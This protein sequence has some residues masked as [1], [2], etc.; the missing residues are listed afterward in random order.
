MVARRV[1]ILVLFS[2]SFFSNTTLLAVIYGSQTAVNVYPLVTFPNTDTNNTMLGYGSFTNGFILADNTT[3]CLF[4]CLEPVS[5]YLDVNGGTLTLQQD[6]VLSGTSI[7]A[8]G[9]IIVGNNHTIWMG[10]KSQFEAAQSFT[11]QNVNVQLSSDFALGCTLTFMGNCA[12]TGNQTVFWLDEAWTGS[13]AG[14]LVVAPDAW[15]NINDLYVQNIFGTN[16]A[17]SDDT[18]V[19]TFNDVQLLQ[20][21]TFIFK[22]GVINFYGLVSMLGTN[23]FVYQS[24]MTSSVQHNS[25]L[26]LD[27]GFT[28][29]YDPTTVAAQNLI[30]FDDSTA[31]LELHGATLHTTTTGMTLKTGTLEITKDS[32]FEAEGSGTG[33]ITLGDGIRTDSDCFMKIAAGITLRVTG[34]VLHY[35][36][37]NSCA[38][39]FQNASSSLYIGSGTTLELQ[40]S[41]NVGNGFVVFADGAVLMRYPGQV[42]SG[43]IQPLGAITFV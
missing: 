22:Y 27:S 41:L 24:G 31:Y 30:G 7:I 23:T 26:Y 8:G 29:S 34:N 5:G 36:N 15:L 35:K 25:R 17:C 16:I 10:P 2:V 33:G 12:L 32:V 21:G 3:T 42:L 19:I 13:G 14:I 40:Q 28:F 20:T 43:S 6:L 38:I 1:L 4:N 9:G 11:L 18:G 39:S 37:L